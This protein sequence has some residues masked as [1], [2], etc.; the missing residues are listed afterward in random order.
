MAVFAAGLNTQIGK[1]DEQEVCEGIDYLG[2]KWSRVV[3][4]MELS[5]PRNRFG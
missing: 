3:I 1:V 2:G 4:L 5:V